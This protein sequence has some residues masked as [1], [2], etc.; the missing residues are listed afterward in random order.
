MNREEMLEFMST[1][2][3]WIQVARWYEG[4][5]LGCDPGPN[6]DRQWV[7]ENG[8]SFRKWWEANHK[9]Q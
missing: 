8:A 7:K 2:V 5:K 3:T 4:E 6:F 1:Q 9:E